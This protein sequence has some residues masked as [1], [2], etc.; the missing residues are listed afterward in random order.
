MRN[1]VSYIKE[2]WGE[3]AKWLIGVLL[4]LLLGK[5]CDLIWPD[6]PVVVKEVADTV[7]VVHTITP[8]PSETDSILIER[9][10]KQLLN[11]E[12]FGK[13]E[14][15]VQ[16]IK[17]TYSISPCKLINKNPYPNSQGY[18]QKSLSSFCFV[19]LENN[20]PFLDISY[21]FIR[22]D[23]VERVNTLCIKVV[24]VQDEGDVIVLDQYFEPQ[25]DEKQFVRIVNEFAPG[26]YSIEA[27]F[28]LNEDK[29]ARFPAFYSQSWCL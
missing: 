20:S 25:K 11:L 26:D 27:G 8:L 15:E 21:Q 2:N 13:Y 24:R 12:L 17:D 4:G 28:F 10:Q 7:K 18:I 16:S 23:Y 19:R 14:T 5:A 3:A 9:I 6:K 29:N 22:N 1:V